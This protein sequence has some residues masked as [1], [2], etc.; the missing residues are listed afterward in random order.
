MT[1]LFATFC[2]SVAMLAGSA[3]AVHGIAAEAQSPDCA[4][5]AQQI[6]ARGDAFDARCATTPMTVNGPQWQACQAEQ[7]TIMAERDRWIAACR[8]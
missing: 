5:W 2:V 4:A 8:R 6:Q 1:K 7:A 3:L